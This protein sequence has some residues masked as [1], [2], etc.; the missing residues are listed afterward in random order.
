MHLSPQWHLPTRTTA[1]HPQRSPAPSGR[2]HSAHRDQR[3]NSK[4][5]LFL[6]WVHTTW[7]FSCFIL[8]NTVFSKTTAVLLL[9]LL[10]W[11]L[12]QISQT[13]HLAYWGLPWAL[14]KQ[15]PNL[16]SKACSPDI[17]LLWWFLCA[18]GKQPVFVV[19]Q[20]RF[21]FRRLHAC[22]EETLQNRNFKD[23]LQNLWK[24]TLSFTSEQLQLFHQLKWKYLLP[25]KI[26]AT[27]STIN[28]LL[29]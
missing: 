10:T 8:L 2:G 18:S 25:F 11:K 4:Q 6:M 24:K 5:L 9:N 22:F 1:H 26:S 20:K 13:S 14:R 15:S 27:A 16:Q 7:P 28:L 12:W 3:A 19:N 17:P 23:N 29:R 21:S